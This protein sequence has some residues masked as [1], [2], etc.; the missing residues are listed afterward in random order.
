MVVT[1]IVQMRKVRSGEVKRLSQGAQLIHLHRSPPPAQGTLPQ[2]V[3]PAVTLG[4][5]PLPRGCEA[6]MTPRASGDE[7]LSDVGTPP[8]TLRGQQRLGW[9]G[10][11]WSRRRPTADPAFL[12]PMHHFDRFLFNKN[13]KTHNTPKSTWG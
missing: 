7:L 10:E 3:S 9:G 8:A 1:L 5:K 6:K 11:L 4:T 2:S 13:I 12:P